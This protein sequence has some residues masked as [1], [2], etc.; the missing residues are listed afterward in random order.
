MYLLV[1]EGIKVLFLFWRMVIF[2]WFV[3]SVFVIKCVG[4]FVVMLEWIVILN[5]II[6]SGKDDFV[7]V[8]NYF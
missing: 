6:K 3:G 2:W 8:N 4:E 1:I 7:I 5:C